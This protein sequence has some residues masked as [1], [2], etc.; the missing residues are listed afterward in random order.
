MRVLLDAAESDFDAFVTMDENLRYQQNL[1]GRTLRIIVIRGRSN[2]LVD[3]TPA[4]PQVLDALS[5][6]SPGELRTISA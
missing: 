5:A 4:G 1:R 2:R 3:L 6:M